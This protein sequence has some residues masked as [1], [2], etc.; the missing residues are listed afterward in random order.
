MVIRLT[1]GSD[2]SDSIGMSH[3]GWYKDK[4]GRISV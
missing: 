3:D 2:L 4:Y 1:I